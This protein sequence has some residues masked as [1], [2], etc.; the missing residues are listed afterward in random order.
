MLLAPH[1]AVAAPPLLHA[2]PLSS[3]LDDVM[4]G[5]SM[6][7]R[8]STFGKTPTLIVAETWSADITI[9]P[10]HAS[11]YVQPMRVVRTRTATLAGDIVSYAGNVKWGVVP[12][13]KK[14]PS[15]GTE[16]DRQTY[17][18]GEY[19]LLF[20]SPPP[21]SATEF[22]DYF[23]A[24]LG[25]DATTTTGDYFRAITD[26]R[27][28]W[29]LDGAQTAALLD[30]IRELPDTN[31]AGD[32]IDRL[33]RA[34]VAITTDSRSGGSFRDL[35]IFNEHT[36]A[37]LSSEQVYLGGLPEIKLEYPTVLDYVAWKEDK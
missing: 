17:A 12:E 2:T 29:A 3:S 26:L 27:N 30:F 11:T 16:L 32:V 31:L 21:T 10:D 20:E 6:K 5:L 33:G 34:G 7:A 35:L 13:G 4:K 25:T 37:I 36:G 24:H 8:T 28:E 22:A 23:A 9:G 15:E 14:A 19:P 18:A 1:A